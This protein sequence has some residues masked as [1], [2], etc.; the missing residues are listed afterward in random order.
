MQRNNQFELTISSNIDN[1]GYIDA[2]LNIID[3]DTLQFL[4]YDYC[5]ELDNKPEEALMQDQSIQIS[6]RLKEARRKQGVLV[7]A[8]R[9][10]C[11]G[12]IV[13]NTTSAYACAISH[14]ADIIEMDVSRSSDGVLYMFHD[15]NEKRLLGVDQN[16]KT[17]TSRQID[18]FTYLSP[19]A[20]VTTAR[21]NRLEDALAFLKGKALIN[22]DRSWNIMEYV[23]PVIEKYSM[24]DQVII[25]T[26][27]DTH[28]LKHIAR[29]P[30][31]FMCI[32]KVE[33]AAEIERVL[34]CG[35]NVAAME[36]LYED[37][38]SELLDPALHAQLHA[39]GI[40]LWSNAIRIK[41][42]WNRSAHH[43]DNGAILD[44]PDVHWGWLIERGFDIIQTDWPLLL[45]M[46]INGRK[47]S[48]Y[49]G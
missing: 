35:L 2:I 32:P 37:E 46:Y 48:A 38:Q 41:E 24:M 13:E 26:N 7:A 11:G 8:H 44:N 17:M 4:C 5:N 16:I 20:E 3:I 49:G 31:S 34:S 36:M 22:L 33:T 12:H 30:F 23:L 19:N 18:R 6:W 47:H 42:D 21:V 39:M 14:R 9:G 1:I 28:L 29:M 25:K 40:L 15:G 27:S 43:D 10:T 45:K